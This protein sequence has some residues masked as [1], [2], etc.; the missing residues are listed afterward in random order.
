MKNVYLGE[1]LYASFDG[2]CVWLRTGHGSVTTNEVVL[3]QAA[4]EQFLAFLQTLTMPAQ[5]EAAA[6]L[7]HAAARNPARGGTGQALQ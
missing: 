7:L 4:L 5:L 3:E 6:A 2:E 1:G